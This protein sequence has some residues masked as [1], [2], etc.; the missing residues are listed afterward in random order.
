MSPGRGG[1]FGYRNVAA[2][3]GLLCLLAA[4]DADAME[5]RRVAVGNGGT[6]PGG[7]AGAA[8]VMQATAG[9]AI[10]GQ[11]SDGARTQVH[12]FWGRGGVRVLA[13]DDGPVPGS[14]PQRLAFG[15]PQPNP[16][17]S[18]TRFNITIPEPGH[19]RLE[20]FDLQGRK[21]ESV[22]DGHLRAGTHSVRWSASVSPGVYLARLSVGG[23]HAAERRLIVL[24]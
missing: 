22:V 7:M 5:F 24:R 6:P 12:G 23:T 8:Q 11:S 16:A 21:V 19:V 13:V 18:G 1:R 15:P 10:V 3:G 17:A 9:Q 4:C 14:S 2:V 20:I